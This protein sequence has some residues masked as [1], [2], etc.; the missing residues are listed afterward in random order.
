MKILLGELR[1]M[2]REAYYN[3]KINQVKSQWP[4]ELSHAIKFVMCHMK[5]DERTA[6]NHVTNNWIFD[7]DTEFEGKPLL[8]ARDEATGDALAYLARAGG[9]YY[10]MG[11]NKDNCK[12]ISKNEKVV[13]TPSSGAGDKS[14]V[15]HSNDKTQFATSTGDREAATKAG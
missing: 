9:W 3:L 5:V 10:R 8:L 11:N 6:Q 4:T 15:R 1:T 7:D 13:V 2:I 12:Q 14:L